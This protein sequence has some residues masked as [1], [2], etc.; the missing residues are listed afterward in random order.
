[1]STH[2]S[3]PSEPDELTPARHAIAVI[4]P[5][6][7]AC[8]VTTTLRVCAHA[9]SSAGYYLAI[10]PPQVEN[11]QTISALAD[12]QPAAVLVLGAVQDAQ[13]RDALLALKVPV[14]ETWTNSAKPLDALIA[15]DN[16]EAGRRAARHLAEKRYARVACISANTAWEVE[17]RAGFMAE[18]SDLGLEVAADIVQDNVHALLDGRNAFLRLLAT[19]GLFDAVFCTSDLLAASTVSEAHN[20]ELD[21]PLD[22]AV[23]GF[24]DDG[25]AV[26]WVPG[27]CTIGVE[28]DAMG[29]H[30]AQMLLKRLN[31]SLAAGECEVLPI[32]LE[33]RLSA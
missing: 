1:M 12:M 6:L 2:T 9:L 18:A 30:V 8:T 4:A 21:V 31:G 15:P 25:T 29:R 10:C 16:A 32:Y 3:P 22:L 26:Q 33:P 11:T 28:P 14:L 19:N 24:T 23:I 5:R 7:D 27:L 20:R 13:L 17:R